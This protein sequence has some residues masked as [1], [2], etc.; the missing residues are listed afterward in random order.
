LDV[1][2]L[3]LEHGLQQDQSSINFDALWE[4]SELEKNK[5]YRNPPQM[6]LVR[7][8]FNPMQICIF[9]EYLSFRKLYGPSH[10]SERLQYMLDLIQHQYGT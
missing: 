4:F 8:N 6:L 3:R 9:A 1:P 2:G 5:K 10:E 7:T